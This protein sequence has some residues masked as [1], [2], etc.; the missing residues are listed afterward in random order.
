MRF[1]GRTVGCISAP[2]IPPDSSALL[3]VD[4][5]NQFRALTE[6]AV[7]YL[8]TAGAYN[9]QTR[10]PLLGAAQGRLEQAFQ[11]AWPAKDHLTALATLSDEDF[12]DFVTIHETVVGRNNSVRLA[13]R[14]QLLSSI[15]T[16]VP[17]K[18]DFIVRSTS[19][20]VEGLARRL[21]HQGDSGCSTKPGF[22]AGGRM[23]MAVTQSKSC[24]RALSPAT[25]DWA[26]DNLTSALM[27]HPIRLRVER[28]ALLDVL[29]M[30][31]YKYLIHGVA[32]GFGQ[33]TKETLKFAIS[34]SFHPLQKTK[35]RLKMM[36]GRRL[37][38]RLLA[39]DVS[40][41]ICTAH[42]NDASMQTSQNSM[43]S[44]QG[45]PCFSHQKNRPQ[46]PSRA[47]ALSSTFEAL[48]Q[49]AAFSDAQSL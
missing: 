20:K 38:A 23:H 5:Q 2:L 18:R 12:A 21:D 43:I 16:S 47:H 6:D 19:R 17:G 8:Y 40:E 7:K 44:S 9:Q 34:P 15:A 13:P 39:K 24:F 14:W 27:A 22:Q 45:P 28:A 46:E 42:A 41:T 37:G 31:P 26:G 10:H 1:A 3:K 4:D 32:G 30:L 33:Q 29:S 36:S 48:Q 25:P 11:S 49:A 35:T